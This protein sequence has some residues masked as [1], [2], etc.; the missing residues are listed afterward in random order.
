MKDVVGKITKWTPVVAAVAYL[1]FAIA[2]NQPAL[3]GAAFSGLLTAISNA[4]NAGQ[5][6]KAH[7]QLSLMRSLRPVP[8]KPASLGPSSGPNS[9]FTNF[10]Q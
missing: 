4:S 6:A 8:C 2:S 10:E 3:V 5:V 1:V 7:S 9:R